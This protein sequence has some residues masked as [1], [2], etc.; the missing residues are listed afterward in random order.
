MKV[1]Q[2]LS[3]H[4]IEEN[5]FGQEDAQTDHVFQKHCLDGTHHPAWDKIYGN[6]DSPSTSVV[7]VKREAARRLC[8]Y[9]LCHN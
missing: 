6:P 3:H 2:F 7:L 4:G 1:Q 5:P 9:K 8:D